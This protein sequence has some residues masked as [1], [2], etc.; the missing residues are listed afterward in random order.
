MTQQLATEAIKARLDAKGP[1][2]AVFAAS[3]E[4]EVPR[5]RSSGE[6]PPPAMQATVGCNDS[7]DEGVIDNWEIEIWS[8]PVE[9]KPNDLAAWRL[10]TKGG[11]PPLVTPFVYPRERHYYLSKIANQRLPSVEHYLDQ[12]DEGHARSRSLMTRIR[13]ILRGTA[14][15]DE[16]LSR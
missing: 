8:Y 4:N 2:L 12:T 10:R 1:R 15:S 6:A 7:Y 16:Q 14:R 5:G 11:D 3:V 13:S 9:P